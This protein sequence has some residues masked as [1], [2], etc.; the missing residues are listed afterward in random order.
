MPENSNGQCPALVLQ[1]LY[2][3]TVSVQYLRPSGNNL[4]LQILLRE[5][6]NGFLPGIPL[7]F[8]SLR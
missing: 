4:P 2:G 8:L 1:S 6:G 5:S 3:E 7:L